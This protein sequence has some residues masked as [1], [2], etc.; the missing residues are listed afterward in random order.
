MPEIVPFWISWGPIIMGSP[1]PIGLSSYPGLATQRPRADRGGDHPLNGRGRFDIETE[2][3]PGVIYYVIICYHIICMW[4][5]REDLIV[6][7]CLIY[8]LIWFA[9]S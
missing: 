9:I 3:V 6:W 8:C 4:F 5:H 1:G 7:Y 2:D